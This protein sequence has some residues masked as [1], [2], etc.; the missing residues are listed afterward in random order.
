MLNLLIKGEIRKSEPVK[1]NNVADFAFKIV[2]PLL[3][4]DVN[5][6]RTISPSFLIIKYS[7]RKMYRLHKS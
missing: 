7:I 4:K 6:I 2:S 3:K 5:E 1:Q